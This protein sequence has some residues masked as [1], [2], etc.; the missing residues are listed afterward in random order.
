MTTTIGT[1][2]VPALGLGAERPEPGIMD[3][4]PRDRAEHLITSAMLRRSYL[5]LGPAQAAVTMGA[6]LL[7]YRAMGVDAGWFELPDSG[8]EYAAATAAALAAVVTTQIGN[9]LAHRSQRVSLRRL[10]WRGTRLL[11]LGIVSEIVVIAAI[12]YLPPLQAVIGTAP[13][14]AWLWLP[15]VSVADAALAGTAL[16]PPDEI[17]VSLAVERAQIAGVAA[18]TVR[19]KFRRD[20]EALVVERLSV[21]DL[22]G[23][24][25][26]ASGRVQTGGGAPRGNLALDVEARDLGG[27]VAVARFMISRP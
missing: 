10:G 1:D 26:V 13:F 18:K 5:W 12:V 25:L 3:R 6:F 23:A 27:V 20:A 11:W 9:L 21:A 8:P 17:A 2:L 7:A 14:P 15:R 22:G 19:A 16:E 4:P 24:S